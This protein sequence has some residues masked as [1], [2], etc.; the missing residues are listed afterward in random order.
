[1]ASYIVPIIILVI[2]CAQIYFFLQ[3]L[4]K[5]EEY[6][7][8]FAQEKTWDISDNPETGFVVGIKGSGNSV[9]ESI[10]NS[11]NEYL[12]NNSGSVIDFSLLKDAVDRHCE[13]KEN[14]VQAL[15]PV[16]LYCGLAGT[17]AGV[18]IG[19]SSLIYNGAITDLLSSGSSDFKQAADGVNEL[20]WGVAWAMIASII[21]IGL[22]TASSLCFKQ[23]KVLGE[24]GKN[25][26]LAWLQAKLLPKLPSDTSNALQR[27]A[28]NLNRF[29]NSFAAN[30]KDLS[31][32]LEKVNDAYKIQA[33]VIKT[34]HDLDV[35]K[36]AT[37]NVTVLRELK[38]CT[39]K[40]ELFNEYLNDIKGYTDVIHK[41]T[42]QF[43]KESDRLHVLEEIRDYFTRHKGEIS[44][45]YSDAEINLKKAFASLKETVATNT[46]EL[47][48][49]MGEQAVEF[50]KILEQE[51]E[52][53]ESISTEISAE[54][55]TQLKQM[56]KLEEKLSEIS[57]IPSKLDILIEKLE[58]SNSSL[59]SQVNTTMGHTI[60]ALK[61]LDAQEPNGIQTVGTT[62]PKWMKWT[63]L[64]SVVIIALISLG[65]TIYSICIAIL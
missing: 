12:S 33:D 17:M 1:M 11:I 30:T 52:T 48:N 42:S 51:K 61:N 24:I 46:Q 6:K 8:I 45:D 37:A 31:T 4:K 36:M 43:E 5:M 28:K 14:E 50:K 62:Y 53:F 22:T 57:N 9:F 63:I 65:N 25:S 54:F 20:L 29:N 34:V 49:R 10:K 27:L 16:P 39:D 44:K 23:K 21:G 3:N 64:G 38:D 32:T 47:H 40:L 19:L 41:F 26:F 56:P 59:A 58:R 60:S 15:T 35:M 13:T 55:S 2:I 7:Q 18:I